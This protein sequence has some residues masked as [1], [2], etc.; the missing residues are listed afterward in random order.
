MM[1]EFIQSLPKAELLV[2]LEGTLEPEM[3]LHLAK[4]NK[5]KL[6]FTTPEEIQK[7]YQFQNLK[8][9]LEVYYAGIKVLMTENDFYDTQFN[10]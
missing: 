1:R 6:P 10:I 4:R 9:F 8:M 2:H 7:A 5:I 3:L